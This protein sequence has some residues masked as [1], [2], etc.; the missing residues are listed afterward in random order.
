MKK[1]IAIL[2]AAL[3]LLPLFA[4]CAGKTPEE[5]TPAPEETTAAPAETETVPTEEPVT[6]RLGALKGA[7][8][9]GLVKLLSDAEEKKAQNDYAFQMAAAADELTPLLLKGEMDI[10][11]VPSNLGSVL[12]N[13]TSGGVR[14]LAVSTLG[15]LYLTESGGETVK[16]WSD[17]KGKTVYSTGKGTT[18]EYA[19]KYLLSQNG[20]DP[21]KD[22]TI[23]WKSEPTEIVAAMKAGGDVVAVLPQPF[24]TVAGTQVEGLRTVFDFTAE[25][26]KLNNGSRL[27]TAG[28]I[29]RAAFAEEHPDALERF[30]EDY[31]AS[32]AYVNGN[33]KDAAVLVEKYGIVKAAV[34]EKAIPYCNIVSISGA[35]ML[36]VIKG[37]L[38]VL[39]E[40]NPASVGGKLPADDY[41]LAK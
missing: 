6:V 22:L 21:E 34:A 24:V 2:L 19:F 36:P 27:V 1:I 26:D 5:T 14:F 4:A 8:S 25:W 18:P 12:Y 38:N 41:Y 9:I 23:E 20:L 10:L 11:V 29:V 35:E 16:T 31:R 15:V 32:V 28:I 3:M 7:T 13:K 40:Q 33:A 39:Y 30:L 37:Y 17:L